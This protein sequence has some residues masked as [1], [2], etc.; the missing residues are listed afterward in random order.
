VRLA[1]GGFGPGGMPG[2]FAIGVDLTFVGHRVSCRLQVSTGGRGHSGKFEVSCCEGKRKDVA[3][4]GI[5]LAGW[6]GMRGR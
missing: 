4:V 1:F 5:G 6:H 2:I 3:R